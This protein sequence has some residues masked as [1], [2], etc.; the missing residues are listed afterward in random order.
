MVTPG[1]FVFFHFPF[2]FPCPIPF[3]FH[4]PTPS[5]DY[6]TTIHICFSSPY[7]HA[8]KGKVAYIDISCLCGEN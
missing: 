3:S 1:L 7:R 2:S 8:E 5:V 6:F 4:L